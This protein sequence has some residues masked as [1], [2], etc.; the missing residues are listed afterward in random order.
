MKHILLF[1][2]LFIM[3]VSVDAEAQRKTTSVKGYYRKDGTY[4]RPHTRSY[5]SGS[6]SR[7][8]SG[9]GSNTSSSGSVKK[10]APASSL[11]FPLSTLTPVEDVDDTEAHVIYVS[12]LRYQGKV[13]DIYPITRDASG[14]WQYEK[15]DHIV[16]RQVFAVEHM[17][18][19][20][21]KYGWIHTMEGVYKKF[22][23]SNADGAFPEYL[24]KTVE[25]IKLQ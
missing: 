2:F 25:A 13:I 17:Q 8:S 24:S 7:T 4:V 15:A 1:L 23:K 21:S 18:E 10:E 14:N 12:V 20:V 16:V 11:A 22:S 9:S 3:L 6:G 5:Q 19:L